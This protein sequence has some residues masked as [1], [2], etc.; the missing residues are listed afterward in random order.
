MARCSAR[1]VHRLRRPL[2][3]QTASMSDADVRRRT[4]PQPREDLSARSPSASGS[5]TRRARSW[6]TR[7]ELTQLLGDVRSELFHYEVRA[8]YDTPEVADSR[9]IVNDAIQQAEQGR[10]WQ[11]QGV[12]GGRGRRP[13]VVTAAKRGG[14]GRGFWLAL[15]VARDRRH[16][17]RW[18][19]WPPAEGP[20]VATSIPNLPALKAEGYRARQLRRRRSR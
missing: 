13:G 3:D 15:G 8:T 19:T 18:A 11:K 12:D 6:R 4:S 14:P 20:G 2:P 10:S 5:S 1:R 7:A 17:A 9:R 16:R